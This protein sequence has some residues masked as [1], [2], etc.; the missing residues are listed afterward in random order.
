MDLHL[1]LHRQIHRSQGSS[2][3]AAAAA[4]EV[5]AANAPD[6]GAESVVVLVAAHIAVSQAAVRIV[7]AG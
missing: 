6:L 1:D 5:G 4:A 3:A 2:A 7:V